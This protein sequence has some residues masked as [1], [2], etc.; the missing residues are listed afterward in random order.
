ME[1][2]RGGGG[3]IQVT[4]SIPLEMKKVDSEYFEELA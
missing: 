3:Y 4:L 1:M 2:E